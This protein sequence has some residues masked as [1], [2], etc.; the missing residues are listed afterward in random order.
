MFQE[1]LTSRHI[2]DPRSY[3]RTL[4][5]QMTDG[6]LFPRDSSTQHAARRCAR[7]R[8]IFSFVPVALA[9]ASTT[10]QHAQPRRLGMSRS[11]FSRYGAAGDRQRLSLRAAGS[12]PSIHVIYPCGSVV[13][14]SFACKLNVR[15]C[16]IPDDAEVAVEVRVENR[17][18]DTEACHASA[19]ACGVAHTPC[20]CICIWA[21][22]G[23]R[24]AHSL[25]DIQRGGVPRPQRCSRS[26]ELQVPPTATHP[27]RAAHCSLQPTRTHATCASAARRSGVCLVQGS[28]WWTR[29]GSRRV[30]KRGWS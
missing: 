20:V 12:P 5:D 6:N 10:R 23:G 11:A 4:I 29:P 14:S 2:R 3:L 24:R 30:L 21:P 9:H 7:G 8:R 15:H 25:R 19:V 26:P 28:T 16:K 22:A 18:S 27:T 13:G 1:H 17:N